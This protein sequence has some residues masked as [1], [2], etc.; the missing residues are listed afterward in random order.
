MFLEEDL[1]WPKAP[2]VIGTVFPGVRAMLR[3]QPDLH[4]LRDVRKTAC[5]WPRS[6]N[7]VQA[8]RQ[9]SP[10]VRQCVAFFLSSCT[11]VSATAL[12]AGYGK[13]AQVQDSPCCTCGLPTAAPFAEHLRHHQAPPSICPEAAYARPR[14]ARPGYS[15]PRRGLS[16]SISSGLGPP[17]RSGDG[18][19]AAVGKGRPLPPAAACTGFSAAAGRRHRR[20]A[21]V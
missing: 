21:G 16:W 17:S 9:Q 3:N 13:T 4:V 10:G 2:E 5:N 20:V 12:L 6:A 19:G 14:H 18:A 7:A 1:P 11:T 8:T 15:R